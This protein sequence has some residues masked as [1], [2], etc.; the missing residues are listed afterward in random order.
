MS[1]SIVRGDDYTTVTA[2]D[3][4]VAG[5]AREINARHA[6]ELEDTDER[7]NGAQA[8]LAEF[9]AIRRG[10]IEHPPQ[11]L[12]DIREAVVLNWY[13]AEGPMIARYSITRGSGTKPV[14]KPGS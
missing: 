1:I 2:L 10:Q 8:T 7:A 6:R 12:L 13:E 11:T 9:C 4:A 14:P 3:A 5:L